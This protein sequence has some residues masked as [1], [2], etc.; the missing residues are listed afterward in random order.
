VELVRGWDLLSELGLHG[1]LRRHGKSAHSL[2]DLA[3][4][5]TLFL[6]ILCVASRQEHMLDN[7]E[8][9]AAWFSFPSFLPP[10]QPRDTDDIAPTP[11]L[12]GG[13]RDMGL[14]ARALG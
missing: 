9:A 4:T 14:G 6:Q 3:I 5:C 13:A 7:R 1:V 2:S 12:C 8:A 11:G 10:M